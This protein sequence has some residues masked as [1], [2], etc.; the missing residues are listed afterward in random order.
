MFDCNELL[1]YCCLTF[2][3]PDFTQ[4]SERL[5]A[6]GASHVIKE[7]SLRR[8]EIKELFKV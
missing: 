2:Q 1:Y 8:P 5:K 3:R 7:E 6:I 4:L